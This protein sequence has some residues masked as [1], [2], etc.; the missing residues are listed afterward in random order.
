MQEMSE[1]TNSIA[2][3]SSTKILRRKVENTFHER[4]KADVASTGKGP[5]NVNMEI[6]ISNPD[7][8]NIAYAIPAH[9]WHPKYVKKVETISAE[10]DKPYAERDDKKL[11]PKFEPEI[12]YENV[13]NVTGATL[14]STKENGVQSAYRLKIESSEHQPVVVH[15]DEPVHVGFMHA[16]NNT[17]ANTGK[18]GL[19]VEVN[20][21]RKDHITQ[22]LVEENGIKF[23]RITYN[24]T[25]NNGKIQ[26]FTAHLMP[27]TK[28]VF[29]DDNNI[30]QSPA[31]DIAS[32][33]TNAPD[34]T[35]PTGSLLPVNNP[36]STPQQSAFTSSTNIAEGSIP[37]D[38]DVVK[39][40]DN[41][42]ILI[43][44]TEALIANEHKSSQ[45]FYNEGNE[46]GNGG[47]LVG[48]TE[49]QQKK[50]LLTTA[51]NADGTSY[52]VISIDGA[53]FSIPSNT[54]WVTLDTNGNM[55]DA[56]KLL[57]EL[58]LEKAKQSAAVA[59]LAV[60]IGSAASG[61]ATNTSLP[62][63]TG[64]NQQKTH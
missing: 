39:Y 52:N 60:G 44:A 47:I 42:T 19:V 20:Q 46:H 18:G 16:L 36:S 10:L 12:V 35:Q 1:L 9:E 6:K 7:K 64:T 53:A 37:K 29:V 4:L 56:P 50:A 24:E 63:I 23:N 40:T 8:P 15:K 41:R 25:D 32:A 55:Q 51:S 57:A 11:N 62:N 31:V 61:I 59:N 17:V 43:N 58:P 13:P 49:E 48:L 38:R 14:L 30:A 34:P 5:S 28:I 54:K 33:F 27:N 22:E 3:D 45:G 21:S 26:K 2:Y